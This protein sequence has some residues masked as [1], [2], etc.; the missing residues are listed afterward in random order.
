MIGGHYFRRLRRHRSYAEANSK[1]AGRSLLAL[2]SRCVVD[3]FARI[4]ELK[5]LVV[6]TDCS[7]PEDAEDPPPN[8]CHPACAE[9]ADSDYCRESWQLHMAELADR[10]ETHWHACDRGRLCA[11]V[12]VVYH[13]RCLA[14]IKLAC[15]ACISEEEF[16]RHV[17]LLDTLVVDFVVAEAAFLGRL[18]AAVREEATCEAGPS[19]GQQK[20]VRRQTSHPQVLRAV[21]YIEES[22]CDPKLSV[23]GVAR[24]LDIH[25]YYLSHLFAE[26]VGQRMSRFIAARRVERAK[27]LLTTTH[28]Q[29]KRIAHETGYANPNWFSHVFSINTGVTPTAYR[30][31]TRIHS[32]NA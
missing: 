21:Q 24:E 3:R 28:W 9:Q 19:Q 30:R 7:R 26:Q 15:L 32:H 17:E 16:E 29:I 13:S 1:P 22:L 5:A 23:A 8:P 2:L 11:Y 6:S 25:P 4:S 12:P 27:K 18:A 14:A 10:P 31:R 20:T